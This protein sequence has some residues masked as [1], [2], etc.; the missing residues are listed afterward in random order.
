MNPKIKENDLL[1]QFNVGQQ[2]FV[3]DSDFE[4]GNLDMVV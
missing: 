4:S 1:R 2:P 3:F